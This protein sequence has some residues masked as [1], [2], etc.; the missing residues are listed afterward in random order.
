[1]S[2]PHTTMLLHSWKSSVLEDRK[3]FLH[4]EQH[5]RSYSDRKRCG[6]DSATNKS[7]SIGA[8]RDSWWE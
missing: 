7:V 6:S 3:G 1:M 2:A 4:D 8:G 5:R